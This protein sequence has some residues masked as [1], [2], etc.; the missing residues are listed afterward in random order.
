MDC[1]IAICSRNRASLLSELLTGL[2]DLEAG[3]KV[4]EVLVIDDGSSDDTISVLENFSHNELPLRFKQLPSVGLSRARNA[5]LEHA[6]GR[7]VLFVDD[8]A[9]P[10][11][12]DW[13]LRHLDSFGDGVGMTGGPVFPVWPQN[14]APP[15]LSRFMAYTYSVTPEV[16][17]SKVELRYPEY[18]FGANFAVPRELAISAGGFSVDHG[19]SEYSTIP[20]EEQELCLRLVENGCKAVSVPE[21]GVRHRVDQNKMNPSWFLA[22][23]RGEGISK[24]T[25]EWRSRR[26]IKKVFLIGWRVLLFFGTTVLVPLRGRSSISPFSMLIR[27]QFALSK[28]YLFQIFRLATSRSYWPRKSASFDP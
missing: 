26:R 24:A 27:G 20:G 13:M 28:A 12:R 3:G 14:E 19:F 11:N 5:A 23:C 21:G 1:S 18:P 7:I 9:L 2:S 6:R 15:W 4:F 10:A 25:M 17:L 8:D 22:R 16:F